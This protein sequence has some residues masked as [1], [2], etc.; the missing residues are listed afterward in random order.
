MS[1]Q[2]NSET[3]LRLSCFGPPNPLVAL[4][5]DRPQPA[6]NPA[7]EEPYS[8]GEIELTERD[9]ETFWGNSAASVW[10]PRAAGENAGLRSSRLAEVMEGSSVWEISGSV[11]KPHEMEPLNLSEQAVDQRKAD[12]STRPEVSYLSIRKPMLRRLSDLALERPR[13]D[14]CRALSAAGAAKE[15]IPLSPGELRDGDDMLRQI[16]SSGSLT[17]GDDLSFALSAEATSLP[18]EPRRLRRHARRDQEDGSGHHEENIPWSPP[19]LQR[20][21]E[22]LSG[23]LEVVVVNG[24]DL[25]D[26]MMSHMSAQFDR[27]SNGTT[28][29]DTR[30]SPWS[31]FS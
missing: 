30:L 4:I 29:P 9:L 14:G 18:D 22:M 2:D 17:S 10:S 26:G 19:G 3:L 27:P 20:D 15:D 12:M 31:A 7:L 28:G 23:P 5:D 11:N 6:G 16:C 1:I 13:S 21:A 25:I 8:D 24:R